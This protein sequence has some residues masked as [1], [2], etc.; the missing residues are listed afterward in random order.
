MKQATI[1]FV[2]FGVFVTGGPGT[3]ADSGN[4]FGFETDTHPLEYEYC[5]KIRDPH[6]VALR[7]NGYMCSSAPRPHPD[8]ETYI[9]EFVEDVGL[10]S[11]IG[12]TYEFSVDDRRLMFKIIKDQITK[13]YGPSTSTSGSDD[14]P[15]Y[16][17]LSEEGFSGVGDVKTIRLQMVLEEGG[18]RWAAMT[19][20]WLRSSQCQEAIKNKADRAF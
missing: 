6:P 3:W 4:P 7:R 17:W 10:C 20:F 14:D 2:L 11:L 9:L 15:I 12:I 18:T 16:H 5:K 13:K 8:F 1:V 19:F